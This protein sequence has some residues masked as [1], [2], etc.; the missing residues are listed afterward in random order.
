MWELYLVSSE[1]A[2]R[3]EG[4]M[5]FQI[6]MTKTQ[7]VVPNTRNYIPEGEARLRDMNLSRAVLAS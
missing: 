5:V 3:E 1:M 6:Q 4:M 2:F 7:A